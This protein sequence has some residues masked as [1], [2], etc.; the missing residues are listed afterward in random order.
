MAVTE[1]IGDEDFAI[2]IMWPCVALCEG[3]SFALFDADEHVVGSVGVGYQC[4][5]IAS[6]VDGGVERAIAG[7]FARS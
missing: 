1:H 3:V 5:V 6:E 2:V 7:K 4:D